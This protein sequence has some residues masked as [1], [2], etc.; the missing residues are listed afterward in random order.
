MVI[1]LFMSIYIELLNANHI[2]S[3]LKVTKPEF[4]VQNTVKTFYN[5]PKISSLIKI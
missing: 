5:L 3:A 1:Y 4:Q 2:K